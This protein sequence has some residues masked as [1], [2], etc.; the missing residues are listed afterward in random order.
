[1]SNAEPSPFPSYF[2]DSTMETLLGGLQATTQAMKELGANI[3]GLASMRKRVED[4]KKGVETVRSTA[5]DQYLSDGNLPKVTA[6]GRK[7][8]EEISKILEEI[9]KDLE[10]MEKAMGDLQK[11]AASLAE[12]L[13]AKRG[14]ECGSGQNARV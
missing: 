2:Q 14:C 9:L 8:W 12:A 11:E 13:L 5:T 7:E 6:S 3:Q 10:Q 1:M 4:M